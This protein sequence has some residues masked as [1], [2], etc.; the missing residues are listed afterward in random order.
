[1]LMFKSR[2]YNTLLAGDVVVV[3]DRLL[4]VCLCVC[5]IRIS[6][7][8]YKYRQ[9]HHHHQHHNV[10]LSVHKT[11]SIPFR[12]IDRWELYISSAITLL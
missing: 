2:Q 11:I 8:C 4:C 1:M 12:C 10:V 3:A 6:R 5:C 7:K 9:Y